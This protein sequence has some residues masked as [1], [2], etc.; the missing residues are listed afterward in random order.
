MKLKLI[1]ALVAAAIVLGAARHSYVHA[2]EP[3]KV[4]VR[5]GIAFLPLDFYLDR[6]EQL[7]LSE[8]QAQEMQKILSGLREPSEKL[9]RMLQER[10]EALREAIGQNPP[11]AEK[12]MEGFKGVMEVENEMKALGFRARM[13]MRSVLRPEQYEKVNAMVSQAASG[14]H[15]AESGELREKLNQVRREIA[16]RS[17]GKP[18]REVLEQLEQ[19]EQA[20]KDGHTAEAGKR[21]DALLR[22]LAGGKESGHGN[23]KEQMRKLEA[24]MKDATDPEQREKIEQQMRRLRE[25]HE[26]EGRPG[27]DK[28]QTKGGEEVEQTIRRIAEAA[29]RADNPEVREQLMGAVRKLKE[30]A[31]SGN[32]QAAKEILQAIKPLV[33]G[34][35]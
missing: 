34:G 6:R 22:G 1:P 21:L 10:A 26:G 25:A 12:A 15:G 19:I 20:A 8:E 4:E 27:E 9:S 28:K 35:K 11:D 7:G 29:E 18:P 13:A 3:A 30:A 23:V 32:H 14:K 24:A 31:E 16:E 5:Y 2:D 33:E 17:G